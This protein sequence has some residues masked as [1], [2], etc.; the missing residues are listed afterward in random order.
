MSAFKCP[1][2]MCMNPIESLITVDVLPCCASVLFSLGCLCTWLECCAIGHNV[3]M[4][5]QCLCTVHVR[6]NSFSQPSLVVHVESYSV[7]K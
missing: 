2:H 7:L 4:V 1:T 3:S 6:F 5:P